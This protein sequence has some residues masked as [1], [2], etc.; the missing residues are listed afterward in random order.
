M[1]R[2]V[3]TWAVLGSGIFIPPVAPELSEAAESFLQSLV[4]DQDG[5]FVAPRRHV[6]LLLI[7]AVYALCSR[8]GSS[9][10]VSRASVATSW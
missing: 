6:V 2:F 4:S 8:F 7:W 3:Y 9:V 5:S 1:L 10:D